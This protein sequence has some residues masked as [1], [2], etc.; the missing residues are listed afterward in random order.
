MIPKPIWSWVVLIQVVQ[1]HLGLLATLQLE[2][3]AHA[4]AVAFV[5]DL[6]LAAID[7]IPDA[8]GAHYQLALLFQSLGRNGDAIRELERAAAFSPVVGQDHLYDTLG[9]LY[10]SDA[11]LDGALR[12]YRQRVLANPNN[13]DAH[14]KLGQIY[15]ELGRHEEASA[16]F[17]ARAPAGSDERGSLRRPRPDPAA[18]GRLRRGREVGTGRADAQSHARCRPVHARRV[19]DAPG[20][21][22]R[23]QGGS[24]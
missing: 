24:R 19:A 17:T 1:D 11:D 9:V 12:A 7:A 18:P 5:T 8:G 21:N 6:L 20:T 23:R 10:T 2:D 4:V 15:L 3:H 22:R 14:R 13:S 16:E